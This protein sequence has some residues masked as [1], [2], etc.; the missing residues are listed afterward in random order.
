MVLIPLASIFADIESHVSMFYL[1]LLLGITKIFQ[2][3]F[4]S[5]VTILTNRTVPIDLRSIMNGVGGMGAGISKAIGP[6]L[7][8]M[9][10]IMILSIIKFACLKIFTVCPYANRILGRDDKG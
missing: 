4:F 3:V 8:G 9:S 6:I 10:E 7:A 1:A 5:S 2:S